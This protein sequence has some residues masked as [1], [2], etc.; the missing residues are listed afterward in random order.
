M[1]EMFYWQFM[2]LFEQ[3]MY[4]MCACVRTSAYA[5]TFLYI[6]PMKFSI[7]KVKI[8]E[9]LLIC[10]IQIIEIVMCCFY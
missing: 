1:Q 6:M 8:V 5:C 2:I 10:L 3:P 4:V 7:V 9:T